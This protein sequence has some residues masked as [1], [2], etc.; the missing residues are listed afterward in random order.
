M[1]RPRKQYGTENKKKEQFQK[2]D[3]VQSKKIIF[4]KNISELKN[5]IHT[6]LQ[7]NQQFLKS[8]RKAPF[9]RNKK[10]KYRFMRLHYNFVLKEYKLCVTGK[11]E[12]GSLPMRQEGEILLLNFQKVN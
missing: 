12:T 1:Y 5:S 3:S 6:D 7:N 10:L 8:N 4:G 9:F 2:F 11:K